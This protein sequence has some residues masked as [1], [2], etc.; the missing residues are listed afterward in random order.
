MKKILIAACITFLSSVVQA[1]Q[2]SGND[3]FKM[4]QE[5]NKLFLGDS[6]INEREAGVYMGY[7]QGVAEIYQHQGL[8]C[9]PDGILGGSVLGMGIGMY[10]NFNQDKLELPARELVYKALVE[11]YPCKK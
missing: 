11:V 3:L 5:Y 4:L 2:L 8:I 9:I 6:S 10:L 1:D 7:I